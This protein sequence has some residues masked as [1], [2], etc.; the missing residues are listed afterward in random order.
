L[1]LT[2]LE[3]GKS[4]VKVP[5]ASG[6]HH[7][8]FADGHLVMCPLMVKKEVISQSLLIRALIPSGRAEPL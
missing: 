7:F 5:V 4:K 1:F 3:A 8:L 6:Y 2:V